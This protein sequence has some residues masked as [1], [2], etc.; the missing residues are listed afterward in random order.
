M[1][2]KYQQI[3]Q[4]MWQQHKELLEEF[5]ELQPVYASNPTKHQDQLNRQGELV[6]EIVSHYQDLLCRKQENSGLS[7]YS[8]T[9]LD[10]FNGLL[11]QDFPHLSQV[12]LVIKKGS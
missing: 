10:K 4:Q 8:Q 7:R 3:Y 5:K 12:G 2:P 1:T 6:L 11:N 9:M